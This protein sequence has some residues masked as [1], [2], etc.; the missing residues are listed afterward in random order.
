VNIAASIALA[1]NTTSLFSTL[2]IQQQKDDSSA[3][4]SAVADFGAGSA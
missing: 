1:S 4:L 3:L 2:T